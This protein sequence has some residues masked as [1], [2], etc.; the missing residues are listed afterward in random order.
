MCMQRAVLP[1][2]EKRND[3]IVCEKRNVTCPISHCHC[4]SPTSVLRPSSLTC[5]RVVWPALSALPV[6]LFERS[7][8]LVQ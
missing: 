7:I 3:F 2:D 1:R 4:L 6:V 8:I 5:S